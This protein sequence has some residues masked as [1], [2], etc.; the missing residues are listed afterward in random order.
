MEPNASISTNQTYLRYKA[1]TP[2]TDKKKASPKKIAKT[3]KP[4]AK[5][6]AKALPVIPPYPLLN[7]IPLQ[8]LDTFL[9]SS[10][11]L[12]IGDPSH[13]VV[14]STLMPVALPTEKAGVFLPSTKEVSNFDLLQRDYSDWEASQVLT[15]ASSEALILASKPF[16]E[17]GAGKGALL[18]V[19]ASEA[20]IRVCKELCPETG[21]LLRIVLELT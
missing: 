12:Y 17:T 7:S 1:G 16:Q 8:Q 19:N 18:H 14:G 11:L 3:P 9:V 4:R 5:K 6:A 20:L 15:G 10:G 21:K 2:V 13:F